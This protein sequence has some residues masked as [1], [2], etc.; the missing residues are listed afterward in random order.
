MDRKRLLLLTL[1]AALT[2]AAVFA[3]RGLGEPRVAVTD[4][5]ATRGPISREVLTSGTLEPARE[6]EVGAQV[7]G[8]VQSIHADFN[9][10]VSAGQVIARLDPSAFDAEVAQARGRLI[11]AQAD[12]ESKQIV[13]GDASTKAQRARELRAQDLISQ[14]EIDAAELAVRQAQADLTSV[15]AAAKSAGAQLASAEVDR[16]HT[17]IRSPIDGVVVN[18]SVEVGQTLAS[19]MQAPVLFR[20][21]DLRRMQMLTEVS[22][23]DVGSIRQGS[24]VT[25]AVE[26]L[27]SSRF[28]GTVAEV[29]LAPVL[30]SGAQAATTAGS[31]V[32][33]PTAT[34]GAAGATTAGTAGTSA[35]SG[36]AATSA[37]PASPA[38]SSAST[39]S[40]PPAGSVVSY[41]AI[42]NVDNSEHRI[43]PGATAIVSLPTSQRRDVLR[44]PNNALSFQPSAAVLEASGQASAVALRAAAATAAGPDEG[45]A[46]RRGYVWRFEGGKFT[47]VEVRTG[48]ADETW[49][50]ILSGA[51]QP[52]DRFVT[53]AALAR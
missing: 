15:K 46:G 25:F 9:D 19:R 53:L 52:G 50:E 32:P 42:V 28:H 48:A 6:V 49:T 51:V 39:Q 1:A 16:S 47:P 41:T 13:F 8:T 45:R 14:A 30:E 11:Q 38:A 36:S 26:S 44:V 33:G 7:S 10:R 3:R 12:V 5:A 43:A 31:G 2:A 20:I 29:R 21:A 34:T 23:A 18:R 37:A 17:V 4:A 40:T 27:G 35:A 22:E 24:D